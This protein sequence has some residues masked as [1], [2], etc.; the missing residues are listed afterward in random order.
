MAQVPNY[1]GPRVMPSILGYR[2]MS[3]NI[4]NV[5]KMEVNFDKVGER[6]DKVYTKFLEEQDEARVTAALTELRRKAVDM[7]TAENG[8]GQQFGENALAPDE[9][10]RGLVERTDSGLHDF[11]NEIASGLTARQQK[12]FHEK[13]QNIY[14]ATYAGVSQHVYQQGVKQKVAAQEGVVNQ[15]VEFGAAYVNKPDMLKQN[16]KD[17]KEAADRL[18]EFQGWTQETKD[19]YVKK[20]TSAMYMNGIAT[21]LAGSDK[22]PAIAYRAL[23]VLQAHSKEMLPSDVARARQQINPIIQAHEDRL[24]VDQL[25]AMQGT[26]GEVLPG[27]LAKA[28]Q[29]GLVSQDVRKTAR[30]YEAIISVVSQGGHQSVTAK[31]GDFA[32]WKHGASQLTVAQAEEA[33]KMSG[34]PWDPKAFKTDR[35]YNQ[36][37][38][39][40]RYN[41][42]LTEFAGDE[43]KSM[44]GY[45]SSVETVR[46]AEKEAKE[47]GGVWTDYLPKKTQETLNQASLN[48]RR[49]QEVIDKA[50]GKTVSGFDPKYAAAAKQWM[51]TDQIREHFR[52]TD[53]R[54]AADPLYCDELVNKASVLLNQK[55]QS[56]VQQQNNV[57]AQISNILFKTHGDTGA[58]PQELLQ[59][60]DVNELADVQ[61]LASHYQSE[62]FASNPFTL[63]KLA[64]DN[65]LVSLNNDE[66]TLYLNELNGKDRSR[67]L[68]KWSALK[69]GMVGATDAKANLDRLTKLGMVQSDYVAP[70]APIKEALSMDPKFKELQKESPEMAAMYVN[71]I[72]DRLSLMGQE[73]YSKLNEDEIKKAVWQISRE[74]VPVSGLFGTKDKPLFSIKAQDLPNS[75]L[76]DV[77]EILKR[78]TKN[79]LQTTGQDREPTENELQYAF[80]KIMLGDD[81]L[82]FV[83]PEDVGFDEPLMKEVRK[84]WGEKHPGQKLSQTQ[85]LRL[86]FKARIAGKEMKSPNSRGYLDNSYIQMGV[87]Q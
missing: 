19:L 76:T 42:M 86:Y 26:N 79:W 81:R 30:G 74:I 70:D 77:S 45:L 62:T 15:A 20:N 22:N 1:G 83:I 34:Q 16:A 50:T 55:K 58:I 52:D 29:T 10:G 21:L 33:A 38:G 4:P 36:S 78:T 6:L 14:Q 25:V 65:F 27:G 13:A 5:P 68:Q 44:A 41:G 32:D 24:K 40:G 61:K 75:G 47:K 7:E 17:L 31:E 43:Q 64:D 87:M 72:Q 80:M 37:L 11:G 63:G 59:Q 2:P 60:L 73:R 53:P 84:T 28:V 35:D 82:P 9:Q 46:N 49:S 54:A 48:M 57:K 66:L 69:Q 71:T 39:L 67:V 12:L 8:W 23:G 51:T 56:Y 18:A 3:D 85:E